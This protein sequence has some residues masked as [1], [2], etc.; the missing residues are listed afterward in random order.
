MTITKTF[1]TQD[2]GGLPITDTRLVF[3]G[4][5][6]QNADGT[7][8]VGV[9]PSTA[10]PLVTGNAGMSYQVA[11]F[12][13]VTSRTGT[14]VELVAN[15]ASLSVATDAAPGSNSRIDVI[16]IQP[17]FVQHTDASNLPLLGVA[18]GVAAPI[19]VKPSIPA[20]ALELATAV[21]LS[22][23]LATNTAVITQT[24]QW[25]AAA[26]GVVW[27]RSS[28]D[29]WN[30]PD[31]SY[32]YRVDTKTL[33]HR[34]GG[35]W[36]STNKRV[37]RVAGTA[38]GSLSGA[39][40][41]NLAA[42]QVIP[43]SPFGVGVPYSVTVLAVSNASLTNNTYALRVL[44]DGVANAQTQVAGTGGISLD[45]EAQQIISSPD[46]T[47]TIDV[48]ILSV[49]GTSTVATGSTISYFVIELERAD[50]F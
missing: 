32:A 13:A 36:A 50:S 37:R 28:A 4:L 27:L 20:G 3:A 40:W 16:Y 45:T 2:A 12:K 30:A 24:A 6:A 15:D 46:A 11:P 22:T 44:I 39:S 23:T 26:G 10:N 35:V 5:V 41:L 1:P 18:K 42:Q 9:L 38:S 47:H 49:T 21:I 8:R 33:M 19:P 48:Q 34:A 17:R 43:A 7:P 31:G 25:T 14:G 29:M